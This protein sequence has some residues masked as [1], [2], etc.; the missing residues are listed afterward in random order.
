MACPWSPTPQSSRPPSREI[1]PRTLDFSHADADAPPSGT[2]R[3]GFPRNYRKP[4]AARHMKL[5]DER[6]FTS[7]EQR[8]LAIGPITVP[9]H[10]HLPARQPMGLARTSSQRSHSQVLAELRRSPPMRHHGPLHPPP[11]PLLVE[12]RIDKICLLHRGLERD[13]LIA[14]VRGLHDQGI[15]V[16]DDLQGKALRLMGKHGAHVGHI[17]KSL[18]FGLGRHHSQ[19]AATP[20]TEPAS[21]HINAQFESGSSSLARMVV[22]DREDDGELAEVAVPMPI[23]ASSYVRRCQQ[24]LAR[25]ASAPP[26][27]RP[28]TS[29][30]SMARPGQLPTLNFRLEPISAAPKRPWTT[31]VSYSAG[32]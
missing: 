6:L 27:E 30:A 25:L 28:S 21:D 2:L 13:T 26:P 24:K 18:K 19:R 12:Q 9:T 1:P 22:E 14:I 11:Y 20:L 15:S 31:M 32:A 23:R 8:H 10:D 17:L 5:A 4:L 16:T 3:K 7:I 29:P